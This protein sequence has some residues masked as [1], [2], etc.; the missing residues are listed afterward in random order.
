MT[1]TSHN[2]WS[3][4]VIV[5]APCINADKTIVWRN[6]SEFKNDKIIS[7]ASCTTNV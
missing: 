7:A 3:K 5:S 4:K 6:E 2:K 1:E